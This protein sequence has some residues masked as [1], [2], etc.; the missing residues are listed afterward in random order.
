MTSFPAKRADAPPLVAFLLHQNVKLLDLAGPLQVFADAGAVIGAAARYKTALVSVGG[1]PVATD[2]GAAITTIAPEGL[3]RAPHTVLVV[4]GPAARVAAADPAF[5]AALTDLAAQAR[6]VGAIC[7]GAF[8]LAAA[9]LLDGRRAV[10]HWASC[11]DLAASRPQVTVEPDGIYVEDDGVWT[12]AGVTAG[13]DLALAMVRADHGAAAALAL[14]RSLVAPLVRA[15]GQSQYSDTLARQ[16]DDAARESR[17][18][19]L[20]DWIDAHLSADLS[21]EAIAAHMA[22]SPRSFTRRYREATGQTPAKAVE[23]ARV[24]C[25]RRLLETTRLSGAEIAATAGFGDDE[26]LRRAFQRRVGVSPSAY[27]ARF[28]TA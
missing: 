5:I 13:I 2:A 19:A 17:F 21:V 8:P 27:R 23:G 9:G 6:R 20:H 7:T 26:R 28:R 25:A 1:G 12:S 14:A 16:E 3:G 10:T 15:G 18:S 4:G 24:A 11:A 22:M